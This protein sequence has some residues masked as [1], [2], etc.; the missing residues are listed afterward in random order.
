MHQRTSR[1]LKPGS[2]SREVGGGV[3]GQLLQHGQTLPGRLTVGLSKSGTAST[4]SRRVAS[5]RVMKGP[6]AAAYRLAG[7]VEYVVEHQAE[8]LVDGKPARG[9][10]LRIWDVIEE[11][12]EFAAAKVGLLKALALPGAP[13]EAGVELCAIG[14]EGW[15]G[16]DAGGES[17]ANV[18]QGHGLPLGAA[19]L[20]GAELVLA[21]VGP[22]RLGVGGT[23]HPAFEDRRCPAPGP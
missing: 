5:N 8:G 16:H 7:E 19:L 21:A 1:D 18:L 4:P 13:H 23:R 3:G 20:V 6:S 14:G 11:G 17:V 15:L 2:E 22:K 9:V 12:G 10:C